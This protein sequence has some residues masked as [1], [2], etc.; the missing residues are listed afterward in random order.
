MR[1]RTV[2]T[3]WTILFGM[4]LAVA[5][6]LP[7]AMAAEVREWSVTRGTNIRASFVE[8]KGDKVVLRNEAGELVE[9]PLAQLT[10]ADQVHARKSAMARP[11]GPAGA[12]RGPA[13]VLPTVADGKWKEVYAFHESPKMDVTI[14]TNGFATIYLKDQGQRVGPPIPTRWGIRYSDGSPTG[15][16]RF[17]EYFQ[18]APPPGAIKDRLELNG[19]AQDKT[20]FETEFVFEA[21]AVEMRV[22][23]REPASVNYK[24]GLKVGISIPAS[25]NFPENTTFEETKKTCAGYTLAFDEAKGGTV[26]LKFHS[27]ATL[28]NMIE[29]ATIK[30]PWGPRV[31]TITQRRGAVSIGNYPST[32]IWRGFGIRKYLASGQK[33]PAIRV[34]VE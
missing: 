25:H 2:K 26:E 30:G 17:V 34:A 21:N 6:S 1:Q 3:R 19:M 27:V 14:G 22:E 24:G 28:T 29:S 4:W 18:D 13:N 23:F 32:P 16:T 31:L 15:K 9:I 8:L 11:A 33:V 20:K 5:G 10:G 12:A 7:V